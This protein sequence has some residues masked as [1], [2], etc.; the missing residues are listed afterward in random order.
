MLVENCDPS[1]SFVPLG[2]QCSE[3]SK[4]FGDESNFFRKKFTASSGHNLALI[5]N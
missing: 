4:I 2:T 1:K 3:S 5:D